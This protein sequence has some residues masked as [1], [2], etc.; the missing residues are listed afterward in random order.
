VLEDEFDVELRGEKVRM[1]MKET[2]LVEG[3][4]LRSGSRQGGPARD[5]SL[6]VAG[7]TATVQVQGRTQ[8]IELDGPVAGERSVIRAVCAAEQKEGA[9]FKLDVLSF[10]A[11]EL[12]KGRLF[13]C[14][15]RES[16]ERGGKKREAFRWTETW[17]SK[18]LR[19]GIPVGSKVENGDGVSP[20]GVLLRST[21]LG[22]TELVLESD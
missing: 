6:S 4:E 8:K 17:E 20:E 2:A 18:G 1:S 9:T 7:R 15:G 21:S 13:R 12:Q 11:E 5:W 10:P 16:L 22:R 3:L 19:N 14:V